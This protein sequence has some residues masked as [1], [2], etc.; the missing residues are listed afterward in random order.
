[1]DENIQLFASLY[2]EAEA[3]FEDDTLQDCIDTADCPRYYQIKTLIMLG[4]SVEDVKDAGQFY[5]GIVLPRTPT[6]VGQYNI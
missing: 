6:Q 2:K 3:K 4:H 5:W 1:M